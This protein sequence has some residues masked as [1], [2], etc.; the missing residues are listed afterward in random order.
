MYNYKRI[1]STK[2]IT[3]DNLALI[4][5]FEGSDDEAGF[6]LVHVDMVSKSG[7]LIEA[8]ENILNSG[9]NVEAL[10]SGLLNIVNCMRAINDSMEK[11]WTR[12]SPKGYESFRTFIMG[13][14]NQV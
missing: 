5:S 13:I 9:E 2:G 1:D 7:A 8:A 6:I 14:T 10:N 11:M 12:S 4:R 3:F